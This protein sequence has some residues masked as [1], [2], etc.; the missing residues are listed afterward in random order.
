MA[1]GALAM[2]VM[3]GIQQ[4]NMADAQAKQYTNAAINADTETAIRESER[5]QLA[6]RQRGQVKAMMAGSGA[7][8][9]S[10]S[11]VDALG[12][13]DAGEA[14][15]L[16]NIRFAGD[17]RSSALEASAANARWAGS[18]ALWG[19]VIGGGLRAASIFGGGAFG[20]GAGGKI[21][22]AIGSSGGGLS[23]G[24]TR[25]GETL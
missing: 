24:L 17:N 10:N 25:F 1:V 19:S 16:Y 9:N 11:F 5:E 20:G 18:N 2:S 21:G 4:K 7:G 12:F 6:A 23:L 13:M 3:S 22:N 8:M 14:T 15:D